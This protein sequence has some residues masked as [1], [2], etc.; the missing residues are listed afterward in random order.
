MLITAII[1]IIQLIF[2]YYFYYSINIQLLF[3]LFNYYFY[4]SINQLLTCQTMFYDR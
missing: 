4:Y 2:N 3:L 1:F